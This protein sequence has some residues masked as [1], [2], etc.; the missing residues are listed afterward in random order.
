MPIPGCGISE[1]GFTKRRVAGTGAKPSK[2]QK[3]RVITAPTRERV[4]LPAGY[5]PSADEEYMSPLQL[6][7]FR[8]KLLK[9]RE[10][11]LAESRETLDH[12]HEE[13]KKGEVFF[14]G[15]T[16]IDTLVHFEPQIAKSSI[17]QKLGIEEKP[18]I[19]VT[20]HRPSNVDSTEGQAKIMR[21]FEELSKK[22]T[23]VLKTTYRSL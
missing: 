4:T 18:Y 20:L 8:Q 13:K 15:N 1:R 7:Y 12:L 16:M 11:L 14:V 6:E 19:L 10:E 22:Y 23:I 3:E 9:W 21:L 17:L 2:P 5:K